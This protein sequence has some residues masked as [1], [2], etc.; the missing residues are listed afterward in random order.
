MSGCGITREGA[1]A[2][3]REHLSEQVLIKHCLATEAI[4]RSLAGS[5]GED[6]DT[7]GIAGLLHDLDYAQTKDTPER[8]ALVTESILRQRG[9]CDEIIDAIKSHNAQAL[10][11]ER[12]DRFHFALTAAENVTGLIV[13]TALVQPDKKIAQV[14]PS[15]VVK[16]MKEKS[17][18]R[19][20]SREG[21]LLCERIGMPLDQFVTVSLAA[22][23]SIAEEL[24]L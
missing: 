2:L 6:P 15:S 17:F 9:V 1:M 22:M 13:A 7:W 20:V 23:G 18:A 10:G 5:F 3:V 12:T 19:S 8:H 4:M 11:I 14:K 24:G 16:R 21:I